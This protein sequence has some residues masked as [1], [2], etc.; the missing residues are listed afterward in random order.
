MLDN[1]FGVKTYRFPRTAAASGEKSPNRVV[2]ER[3]PGVERTGGGVNVA[4]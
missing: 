4:Q 3:R 2:G 1:A